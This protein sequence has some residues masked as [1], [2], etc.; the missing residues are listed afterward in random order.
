MKK[1]FTIFACSL[2]LV[3]CHRNMDSNVYTQNNTIGVVVEGEVVSA[4]QVQVK[5][6]ERL[7]DNA[8][9]GLA[10]G[11]GGAV[12][13]SGIGKGRGSTLGGVGGAV[14]GAAVGALIQDALSTTK[15]MEYI[16]KVT[17]EEGATT[18]RRNDIRLGRNGISDNVKNSIDSGNTKT[19]LISV[20]QG[21][22]VVFGVGQKVYVAYS[23][24]NRARLIAR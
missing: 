3:S 16:V 11:V 20:V 9:G 14:A 8:L 17:S 10:G 24:D 4:R 21:M 12:A 7:Q 2:L 6:T 22:D 23:D 18:G 5:E 1:L 19:K 13:G 15:A